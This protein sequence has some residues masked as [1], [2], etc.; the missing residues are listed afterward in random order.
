MDNFVRTGEILSGISGPEDSAKGL[1]DA[2]D[3]FEQ[4][5]GKDIL[6]KIVTDQLL[7]R[8]VQKFKGQYCP[9]AVEDK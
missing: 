7:C 2:V 5:L 9:Q 6:Q 8:A 3:I 4:F 1:T